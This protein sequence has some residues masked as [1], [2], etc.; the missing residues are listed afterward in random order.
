MQYTL[1]DCRTSKRHEKNTL[2]TSIDQVKQAY[3]TRGFEIKAILVDGQ[4]RQIQQQIE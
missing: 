1:R 4:F 3:Q 2:I